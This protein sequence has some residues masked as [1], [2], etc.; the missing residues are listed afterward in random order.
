V[1]DFDFEKMEILRGE[2]PKD[3][4][5]KCF[6]LCKDYLGGNW[7]KLSIDE[8]EVK[9]L[10]GGFTNQLYY[11]AISK[12]LNPIGD[13]HQEVA[14]RFYGEKHFN[15]LDCEGNERLTDVIIA[16]LVSEYNLGPKIYGLF[17]TG[18]IQAYYKVLFKFSPNLLFLTFQ[19]L[20]VL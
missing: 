12:P 14:I 10:S 5:Q 20:I 1:E 19:L 2:T 15:N 17:K 7:L 8:I 13:E 3:I 9:R 18:Q 4:K 6:N 11:C 16:L